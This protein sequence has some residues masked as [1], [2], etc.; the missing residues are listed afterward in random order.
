MDVAG[1]GKF[2][3]TQTPFTIPSALSNP[4][5]G[6][7]EVALFR[8]DAIRAIHGP[9]STCTKSPWYDML[10]KDRS[11]H[12][13][14]QPALHQARRRIWDQGFSPKALLSYQQRV[15]AKVALLKQNIARSIDQIRD[16]TQLFLFFGFDVMGDTAFGQGFNLLETNTPHPVMQIMRSGIFII[17]RLTPVPWLVILLAS[18]PGA[19]A[20]FRKLKTFAHESATARIQ[21]GR[22]DGDVRPHCVVELRLSDG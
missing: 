16:C 11:I 5:P 18:L 8:A 9:G 6:P 21:L 20:N 4:P 3:L 13:T 7:N 10:Q 15:N 19:N 14:R 2:I 1:I 12:A 17:G 22:D